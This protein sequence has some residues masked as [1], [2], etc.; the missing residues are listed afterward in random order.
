LNGRFRFVKARSALLYYGL[1]KD[2]IH[3]FKYR[4]RLGHE[5]FLSHL[6]K[7]NFHYAPGEFDLIVTVPMHI[8]KL[9]ERNYN[10]SAV[11]AYNLAL[12]MGVICDLLSL[13]K[14]RNTR[15]QFEVRNEDDRRRNFRGAFSAA[16]PEQIPG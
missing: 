14:V 5:G 3:Q 1:V 7:E 15:P 6:M 8:S 13:K 2:I 10:L 9:R 12:S 16:F 11:L 4:G